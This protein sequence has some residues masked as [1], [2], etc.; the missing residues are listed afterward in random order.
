MPGT[1]PSEL[2]EEDAVEAPTNNNMAFSNRLG[3]N[4]QNAVSYLRDSSYSLYAALSNTFFRSNHQTAATPAAPRPE[5]GGRASK[6]RRLDADEHGNEQLITPP[7]SIDDPMDIDGHDDVEN[8]HMEPRLS[9][10]LSPTLSPNSG[11]AS[12][13][14]RRAARLFPAE[15]KISPKRRQIQA[16]T[17]PPDDED[18]GADKQSTRQAEPET[19]ERIW[20]PLP[21]PKYTNIR[22]FFDHDDEYCLPGF[23]HLRMKPKDAKLDELAA[24]RQE[25]LRIEAEKAEKERQEQLLREEA[26]LAEALRPLGLRRPKNCLI[27]PLSTFWEQKALD[28]PENGRAEQS[29]WKGARHKEGVE[30]TKRDFKRLVPPNAWLNDNA[31]QASLVHLATY[32]NDAAG[33]LPK[34]HTPKCIALSSQ[35]WSNYLTEPKTK[36]YGRG[37]NRAWGLTP[38]NLLDVDTVLI[39]VNESN[40][41]TLI[42]IRPSRRTVAY[43]DSFQTVGLNHIQNA[44]Q[45]LEAYLGKNYIAEEWKTERYKVPRQTNGYD[46]GMFVIT[47]SI[48][49]SLGI[50]PSGYSQGDMPLQRLRIAAMLMNGGFTGDFDLSHL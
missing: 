11:A 49:L 5:D 23:E 25:R 45:W 2:E 3:T 34:Q 44:H 26:R 39:P 32:I 33:V 19:E 31:I 43:V 18:E 1:W 37:L 7:E 10:S 46:C 47:N 28:A 29:K 24:Q 8:Q 13:A 40:H 22:D 50:D 41:W 36:L 6:R 14:A 20:K 4:L 42:V 15:K 12:T 9:S 21:P 48:Y 30:L 27:T 38:D 17:P 35:Y 16:V